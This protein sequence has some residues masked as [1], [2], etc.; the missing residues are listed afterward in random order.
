MENKKYKI[1]S[2][3]QGNCPSAHSLW[4][5]AKHDLDRISQLVVEDHL[6]SCLL[7][8]GAVDGFQDMKSFK[9]V[10]K[11]STV[12]IVNSKVGFV[13]KI[14]VAI[15]VILISIFIYRN[16]TNNYKED[17]LFQKS[18][19]LPATKIEVESLNG[20]A[21]Q[22]S[23][24]IDTLSVPISSSDV[25]QNE[26]IT[27]ASRENIWQNELFE[28][29]KKGISYANR[30]DVK[31]EPISNWG[32]PII[33]I[34][35]LKVMDFSQL[36]DINTQT[37]SIN[38]GLHPRFANKNRKGEEGIYADEDTVFYSDLLRAAL[39]NFKSKNYRLSIDRF[40]VILQIYPKDDNALFYAALAFAQINK[41]ENSIA[42]FKR[43]LGNKNSAFLQETNWHLA[44]SYL[45]NGSRM[46]GVKLLEKIVSEKGYY[47]EQAKM[48]LKDVR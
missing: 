10:K 40:S 8:S 2:K 24:S 19:S 35:Q 21:L 43:V 7:C 4:Q 41:F 9:A 22:E 44:L 39:G 1:I 20:I 12:N 3:A 26:K 29:E 25:I 16:H 48:K 15:L 37:F 36:Y 34:E 5:Y 13:F 27:I 45:E 38:T 30:V 31:L 28:I 6:S 42:F 14:A 46:E 18:V 17:V 33:Y 11:I 32:V 23:H 47:A